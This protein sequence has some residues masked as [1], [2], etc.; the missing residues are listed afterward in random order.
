MRT[1]LTRALAAL[2][3][4]TLLCVAPPALAPSPAAAQAVDLT[5][6]DPIARALARAQLDVRDERRLAGV[7]LLSGGLVSVI[8]GAIAAGAGNEDPFWLSFGLGSA[9]WGAVN[10][11]LSIGMLD[12]GD[13]RQA[14]IEED[15][16]L[17]GE[18]LAERRERAIREQHEAATIFALNLGLDVLYVS[19]GALLFLLADQLDAEADAQ[20][21][22]GYA[23]AQM[24]QG[25][26][27]FAFDLAEWIGSAAR[28]DR[29]AEVPRP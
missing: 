2:P 27:L 9:A 18:A 7:A 29:I 16:A 21:L 23:I 6:P 13:G 14:R 8:G 22:R 11:G 20:A 10:A 15:L 26:F 28:A 5:R 17:R 19:V 1:R 4:L 3:L 25:A 24:G 12:V